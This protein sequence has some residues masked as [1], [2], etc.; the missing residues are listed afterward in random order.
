MVCGVEW[1]EMKSRF[2][3]WVIAQWLWF[4]FDIIWHFYYLCCSVFAIDNL[5]NAILLRSAHLACLTISFDI[6]LM[7]Q[8]AIRRSASAI[9][10]LVVVDLW[11]YFLS[12]WVASLYLNIHRVERL[13]RAPPLLRPTV[14]MARAALCLPL[15][16][17]FLASVIPSEAQ[18]KY[19]FWIISI[20]H[21]HCDF[22]D[23]RCPY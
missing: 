10:S 2:S 5:I 7:S 12:N 6:C 3:E 19:I 18:S 14:T 8:S 23:T 16:V 20:I 17:L 9:L 15:A 22:R 4:V 1:N 13:G 21:A 11:F